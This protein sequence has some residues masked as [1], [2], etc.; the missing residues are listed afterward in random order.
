MSSPLRLC[1]ELMAVQYLAA[2]EVDLL[3]LIRRKCWVFGLFWT[4]LC[5]KKYHGRDVRVAVTKPVDVG[6]V[7]MKRCLVPFPEV[8][9]SLV[10]SW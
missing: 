5:W 9:L 7:L 10:L 2:A 3:A 6:A 4:P 1:T 8:C